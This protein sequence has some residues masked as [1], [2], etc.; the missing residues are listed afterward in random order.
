MDIVLQQIVNAI[1][2]GGIYA[3]LALGLAV[4]FSIIS[5]I[6]FAHG[7]LMTL[8]GY[9][10]LAGI[11]MG[12]PFWLAVLIAVI[13]GGVSAALMEFAAFRPVRNA[14]GATLLMTSFAVSMLLQVIFQNGISP[15]GQAVPVPAWLTTSISVGVS[16]ISKV[17][18][19]SITVGLVALIFLKFFFDR[20]YWG[21]AI[22][23][24]ANDFEIVGLMGIKASRLI[25]FAFLLSGL[26]AGIAGVL[27]VVQRGSVDPLMGFKP[28]LAAFIV[29]VIGGL[30]SLTGAVF[31]GFI[32]SSIE[33]ALQTWL[34]ANVMPYREAITYTIVVLIL[35][36]FPNGIFGKRVQEKV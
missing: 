35:S 30:G 34:P 14:S 26:L 5:L 3:L 9:V 24:A 21:W 17:Q 33:I 22:K 25:T 11:L 27:W 1:S 29:A 10:L 28:V 8:T 4:I 15:R 16:Q 31:G 7:E 36:V 20:S 19:M 13:A 32:L 6:N 18:I 23:A 12:Q 2:L